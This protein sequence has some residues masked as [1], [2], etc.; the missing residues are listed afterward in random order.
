MAGSLGNLNIQLSLETIKFQQ[1]LERSSRDTQR[2]VKQF[3]VNF[4]N[5]QQKAK[6]FSERT[7]KYLNNIEQA[8][9]N[10]NNT[11]KWSFRFDNFSRIAEFANQFVKTADS[12]TELQN[13]IR[14]VT[15]TQ[16]EMKSATQAVFDISLRTNQAVGATAEVYQRFAKNAETL[17]INQQQVAEL[18]ET[19]SKAV[20]MSGASTA[21]A[22][23]AL[24]QFGQAMAIADS[25]GVTI[26]QV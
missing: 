3:Q 1:A 4:T 15:N 21:S 22:E 2:F 25:L 24:M 7:T 26:P 11:T 18:T 8:A 14:L 10:I 17:K 19:V 6:Q 5:A 9:K 23:A 16:N 20:A 13:R 12:Y